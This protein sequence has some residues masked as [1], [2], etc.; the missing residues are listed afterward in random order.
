MHQDQ[1]TLDVAIVPGLR[2]GRRSLAVAAGAAVLVAGSIMVAGAAAPVRLIGVS[3]E[4]NAVLIES[5]EPVAYSVSQPDPLTVVVDLRNVTVADARSDVTR[6]GALAGVRLEQA[7]AADGAALARIHVSLLQPSEYRVRSTRNTIRLELAP[8]PDP[9]SRS[10][11]RSGR[12]A[13]PSPGITAPVTDPGAATLIE[14]IRSRHTPSSTVVTLSGNGQL[15]PSNVEE[16]DDAPRRLVL[17]FPDVTT[18][19]AA[20][21][22]VKGAL[23]KKVRVAV[24]NGTPLVTRVVMEL[25]DEA[26]YHVE[27]SGP[28]GSDLDVV[29]ETSAALSDR[30][31]LTP[32]GLPPAV[33]R[34]EA[35]LTVQQA[36]R[37][38][39]SIVPEADAPGDPIT[40]LR[41]VPPAAS[42]AAARL[43]QSGAS[44]SRTGDAAA[45][46][47]QAGPPPAPIAG[48]P[49]TALTPPQQTS[50][51]DAAGPAK[52]F[53]GHPIS[54]DFQ[55]ADLRAVLRGFAEISGLNMVIDP[56]VQ[57]SVDILLNEVPWDQALDVILR[58]NQLDYTVDGSIV[59]I[60]RLE[61]LRKEQDAR[62]ALAKS[63]A[64]AGTLA[65]RTVA[66]NYARAADI[67]PMIKKAALSA[68]G[69]VQIDE[70]TNTLIITDLP[71]R[72]DMTATLLAGLDRAER[73]VEIEARVITTTREFAR[74]I[75][76]QWGLNGRMTPELGNTTNLAFPNSGTLTGRLGDDNTAISLPVTSATS[77]I[78]LALGAVNGAFNLDIA[79]TA[80]EKTGKGRILSTPRVTTQNNVE[81]E[82]TQ[83]V[84]IPVV[85]PGT[86]T[87]PDTTT[88]KDAALTLKVLPRITNAN[89]VIMQIELVNA[90]PGAPVP[91]GI[92]INTQRAV[93][94]VQVADGMTT[95]MGGVFITREQSTL[96][97]TPVLHRIPLLGW[98]FRRDDRTDDTRELLIFI[99]P[100]ILKD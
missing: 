84:Q 87:S 17:E 46:S 27:R 43:V 36:M 11:T 86:A 68:R 29:F 48:P 37:N 66:L 33:L 70:R 30:I 55:G 90:S 21:I 62:T 74:A 28:A 99:T 54:L 23:V 26:V 95:V 76:V 98:L 42:P 44:A 39:A 71:A 41:A 69:D 40:A 81:A 20:Q 58:G 8:G 49:N 79:L 34:A 83:G 53:T 35:P 61:T 47:S 63:A 1:E 88:Y 72:L 16:P 7:A 67:A 9:A 80:L 32:A 10:D 64:E 89:T 19:T 14:R 82:I 59:R 38:V 3:S 6:T 18:K 50:V 25:G 96:D 12:R 13:P 100:R 92:P 85:T 31:V 93:T 4:A 97:R 24:D 15:V 60:A 78:G 77:A 22:G 45:A 57:G 65:V 51:P 94:R 56:D 73:Q 52:V 75:G 2:A 91:G 5:S